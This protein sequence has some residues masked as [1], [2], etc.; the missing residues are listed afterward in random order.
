MPKPWKELQ[1]ILPRLASYERE[2][3]LNSVKRHGIRSPIAILSDGRIIDGYHRWD[4]SQEIS[5]ECPQIVLDLS[6]EDGFNLGLDLNVARRQLTFEQLKV[7]KERLMQ[8]ALELLTKGKTLDE[9]SQITGIPSS[10]ISVAKLNT[11]NSKVGNGCNDDEFPDVRVTIPKTERPKILEQYEKGKTQKEIATEYKVSQQRVS[12]LVKQEKAKQNKPE[13][14]ETPPFP[15]QQYTCIVIDPPWPVKKIERE[16]RP[17]QG[18]E[19][20]YPTKNLEWIAELPIDT[21]ANPK[22]CHV[23]LW[24]T[25]KFLPEGLK[26]F[27]KWNVNYQCVLTWVKPTGMTPFSW[28]YNTEHVLFGHIGSLALLKKGLKLSFEAPVIEH[29][30]KPD[31]FYAIV[32]EVSP[33]PR[34][35]MF[36]RD[37]HDGF[38]PWGNAVN[39]K[40]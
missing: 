16:E 26:L 10:T 34:L 27:E 39:Q 1:D 33:A 38:D 24:V 30:K 23:Y 35:E 9:A 17:N 22:G 36:T 2:R 11:T 19:L 3:L 31:K 14:T 40:S 29:S 6:E 5:I 12:T 13:Q 18:V 15:K 25:H 28:M 32:R 37:V 8:I 20:D 7:A 21:L 4:I